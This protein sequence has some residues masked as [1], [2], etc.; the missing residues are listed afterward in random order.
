MQK[1]KVNNFRF[2]ENLE[3]FDFSCELSKDSQCETVLH[4]ELWF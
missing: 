3:T 1:S 4:F 2:R